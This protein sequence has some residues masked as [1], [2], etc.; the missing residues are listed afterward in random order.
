MYSLLF[1]DRYNGVNKAFDNLSLS[2]TLG[3]CNIVNMYT[4][5]FNVDCGIYLTYTYN[6]IKFGFPTEYDELFNYEFMDIYLDDKKDFIKNIN[7]I[8]D[9]HKYY[10]ISECGVNLVCFSYDTKRI[11][12]INNIMSEEYQID[13]KEYQDGLTI[14]CQLVNIHIYESISKFSSYFI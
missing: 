3:I 6:D 2:T 13:E 14:G 12:E 4:T 7:D 9:D 10:G 8:T 11:T 5:F 1:E